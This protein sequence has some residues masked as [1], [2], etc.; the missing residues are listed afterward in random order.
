MALPEA[1]WF[2]ANCIPAFELNLDEL[3]TMDK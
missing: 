3:G 2:L 1:D